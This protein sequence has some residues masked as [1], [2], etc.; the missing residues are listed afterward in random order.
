[1][2]PRTEPT[3]VDI[4]AVRVVFPLEGVPRHF[5][6]TRQD[7]RTYYRMNPSGIFT[8]AAGARRMIEYWRVKG[9][10]VAE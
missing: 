8:N 7:R 10:I 4:L 9:W 2:I 3:D 5:E 1:M 6:R